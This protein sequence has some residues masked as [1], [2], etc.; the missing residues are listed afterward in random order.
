MGDVNYT[1]DESRGWENNLM[2]EAQQKVFTILVKKNNERPLSL[3]TADN[4]QQ[5]LQRMNARNTEEQLQRWQTAVW[6]NKRSWQLRRLEAKMWACIWCVYITTRLLPQPFYHTWGM[7]WTAGVYSNINKFS[8]P[9]WDDEFYK[10][11]ILCGR[12]RGYNG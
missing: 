9:S 3:C 11:G 1:S 6:D 7:W 12:L 10:D 8:D 4:A 5:L 2:W